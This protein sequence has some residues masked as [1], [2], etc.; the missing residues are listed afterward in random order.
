MFRPLSS[1]EGGWRVDGLGRRLPRA[2]V[3]GVARDSKA[4]LR[5]CA[6]LTGLRRNARAKYDKKPPAVPCARAFYLCRWDGSRRC[7][8]SQRPDRPYL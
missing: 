3:A 4:T 7:V 6:V 5:T 8:P 2:L 1:D